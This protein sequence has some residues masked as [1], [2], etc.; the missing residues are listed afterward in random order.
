MERKILKILERNPDATVREMARQLRTTEKSVQKK[1]D[2]LYKKGI[3]LGKKMIIDWEKAGVQ[4]ALALIDVKVSPARDVGFDDI[5]ERVGRFPEVKFVY[6]V[7]GLYDF[8]ILVEGKTMQDVAH[9]IAEKLA[10]LE[11]VQSTITHFILRKYKEGGMMTTAEEE[12]RL[13]LSP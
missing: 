8:S 2:S 11:R 1:L 7:S 5:A 9:F 13:I 3:I 4:K 10:P 12:E 6:L